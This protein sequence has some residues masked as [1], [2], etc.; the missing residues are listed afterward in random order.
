MIKIKRIFIENLGIYKNKEFLFD[1]PCCLIV[2]KNEAGKS[3]L[4]N[5]ILETLYPSKQTQIPLINGKIT[6][7]IESDSDFYQ[8]V[9]NYSEY[10]IFKNGN[11]VKYETKNRGRIIKKSPGELIFNLSREVFINTSFL[12]QKAG[13]NLKEIYSVTAFLEKAIDTGF[14]DAS[15][16]MALTKIKETLFD[17]IH[18]GTLFPFTTRGKL[19]TAI[20]TWKEK[21]VEYE[22]KKS[23]LKISLEK[24][25]E[26]IENYAQ[27]MD[28][29]GNINDSLIKLES[30]Y[31]KWK[32]DRDNVYRKEIEKLEKRNQE[33]KDVKPLLSFYIN[34]ENLKP[35]EQQFIILYENEIQ[36]LLQN[37]RLKQ[38]RQREITGLSRKIYF[39]SI[40]LALLSI[41]AGFINKTFFYTITICIPLLFYLGKLYIENKKLQHEI[42]ELKF[43]NEEL[44][45]HIDQLISKFSISDREEFLNI[46]KKMNI[47]KIHIKEFIENSKKIEELKKNLLSNEELDFYKSRIFIETEI[48]EED[49]EKYEQ[50]REELL[51]RKEQI[52]DE[53]HQLQSE[54]EK[55]LQSR[56][57]IEKI[58]E[59]IEISSRYLET[60]EKFKKALQK[61]YEI[62]E[63]ITKKHH[64]LWAERLNTAG[65]KLLSRITGKT[66]EIFFNQDLSFIVKIPEIEYPLADK[67][68]EKKLSGGMAEQIYLTVRLILSQALSSNVKVPI[69]LDEPFA[70]SDD[71]RFVKGMKFLIEEIAKSNQVIIISCHQH[72]LSLLK[73]LEGSF[74]L[75]SVK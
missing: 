54:Y 48:N 60:L 18:S 62:I 31:F 23:H 7:D 15:A 11:P 36:S 8:I 25:A 27:L 64:K 72:R 16:S 20:K 22:E 47:H 3:L 12:T 24:Q 9:R 4:A 69:I 65:S 26:I 17:S 6:V 34:F 10:K 56:K 49:I 68:I 70:H 32:I 21:I 58:E 53:L 50:K 67:E 40:L 39:L 71:E 2:D 61:S 35:E 55:I 1:H 5:S 41:I 42:R 75:I 43:K 51:K 46:F 44:S 57:E 33:L 19:D 73:E 37:L 59:Q 38:Q 74:K 66:V 29:L 13:V 45:Q 63:S 30:N 28:E 14:Q 52:K